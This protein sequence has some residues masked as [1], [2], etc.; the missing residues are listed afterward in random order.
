MADRPS[1]T[2]F[3]HSAAPQ[4]A[5]WHHQ[6]NDSLVLAPSTCVSGCLGVY[7]A[8]DFKKG[9]IACAIESATGTWVD[10]AGLPLTE[11][12]GQRFNLVLKCPNP[13][14]VL[15]GKAWELTF[16]GDANRFVWPNINSSANYEEIHGLHANVK[17]QIM[18]TE[19]GNR[20]LHV[21]FLEDCS[22]FSREIL[23]DYEVQDNSPK[24]TQLAATPS[25]K[26]GMDSPA[27]A[28][29]LAASSSSWAAGPSPATP[30]A[31]TPPP[32]TQAV[33]PAPVTSSP[34]LPAPQSSEKGQQQEV[35][36]PLVTEAK[37]EA[38]QGLLALFG[39]PEPTT[40]EDI[41]K[42][43]KLMSKFEKPPGSALYWYGDAAWLTFAKPTNSFPATLI[44]TVLGGK[45]NI[46][47]PDHLL[48]YELTPK[49]LV[50]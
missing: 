45:V 2:T 49:T 9:D 10:A 48:I 3:G 40:A 42:N 30:Q 15:H 19:L 35:A 41:T 47:V 25:K 13:R 34:G 14:N 24:T 8:R 38:T 27:P 31:H 17:L 26:P 5:L 33:S 4:L 23:L 39:D 1:E 21:V 12:C 11:L 20:F 43:G 37:G 16:K 6:V 32:L 36:V 50:W 18:G 28:D 46:D 7:P 44:A 29:S 22:A